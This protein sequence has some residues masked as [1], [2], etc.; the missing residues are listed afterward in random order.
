M[1]G[2]AHKM[3]VS[4][5]FSTSRCPVVVALAIL[6]L[7]A[8]SSALAQTGPLL[9]SD[10]FT[11]SNSS[12]LGTANTGQ[13][14]T[15][16]YGSAG[17]NSNTAQLLS[18]SVLATLDSA[19]STGSVSVR[20]TVPDDQFWLVVRLTNSTNYWRFGRSASGRAYELQQIRNNSIG[21]PKISKPATRSAQ[22]G[23]VLRCEL[24]NPGIECSVNGV[25]VV[26]TSDEFNDEATRVGLAGVSSNA[27]FDNLVVNGP[28]QVPDLV[29]TLTGPASTR[30]GS[31]VSWTATLKNDGTASA[32]TPQLN[33]KPPAGHP[34]LT[35]Q[36]ATCVAEPT[37]YRC[38]FA[39]LAP[40]SARTATINLQTVSNVRS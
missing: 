34:N 2:K 15:T 14:W 6:S 22:A 19:T 17:I 13:R 16:H 25:V 20:V 28:P 37:L 18:S 32:T 7:G 4:S 29:V 9:V 30:V 27:R 3:P 39:T 38:T 35:I 11:R 1:F 21:S 26:R 31:S 8:Q 36:G 10:T 24:G 33:I 5:S 40:N 23:D 12:T